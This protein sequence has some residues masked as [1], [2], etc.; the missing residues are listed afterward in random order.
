MTKMPQL[1]SATSC[2]VNLTEISEFASHPERLSCSPHRSI[3]QEGCTHDYRSR[4]FP[5]RRS[6]R[7]WP[8]SIDQ[9]G[10]VSANKGGCAAHALLTERRRHGSAQ[11]ARRV[12]ALHGQRC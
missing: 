1:M 3:H 7:L 4:V 12:G 6:D 2:A 11:G 9:R 5:T 8:R 10:L